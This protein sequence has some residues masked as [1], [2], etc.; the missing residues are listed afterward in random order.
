METNI[1]PEPWIEAGDNVIKLPNAS[2]D[3]VWVNE[4]RSH[5]RLMTRYAQIVKLRAQVIGNLKAIDQS[6]DLSIQTEQAVQSLPADV[7]VRIAIRAGLAK[8]RHATHN[9]FTPQNI[10]GEE[11]EFLSKSLTLKGDEIKRL[12]KRIL[13]ARPKNEGEAKVLLTF[14]S[15]LVGV[16]RKFEDRCL[17]DLLAN[18]ATVLAA[19][20]NGKSTPPASGQ[21]GV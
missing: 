2:D 7:R 6:A 18:C 5:G 4:L 16:G 14:A 1:V 21:S 17:A 15:K 13:T 12:E 19:P 8:V 9:S 11:I 3:P 20:A 10:L